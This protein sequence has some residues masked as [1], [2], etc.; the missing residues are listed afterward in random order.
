MK[1]AP[2]LLIDGILHFQIDLLFQMFVVVEV[3]FSFRALNKNLSPLFK[4]LDLRRKNYRL[5][6]IKIVYFY[7]KRLEERN[8]NADYTFWN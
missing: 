5:R 8:I 7:F 6:S 4:I 3:L 1:Y 2:W